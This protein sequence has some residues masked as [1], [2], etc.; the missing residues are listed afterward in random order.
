MRNIF[1]TLSALWVIGLFSCRKDSEKSFSD[2]P[3]IT[4][5]GIS[6]SRINFFDTGVA[7]NITL[8]FT[9]GDG[10]IGR[11]ED[12]VITIQDFRSDTLYKSYQYPFPI[13]GSEFRDHKWLEGTVRITLN[14][15][16]FTPRLDS[17]HLAEKKDTLY[18]K[19]YLKDE[20]GN[21]SNT[22]QTATIYMHG[23]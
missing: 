1:L 15:V 8:E 13:I 11:K 6:N 16:F 9:D 14:T 19:I 17:L 20:A 2:T 3:Q 4:Y 23:D 18:F 21:R 12:S 22:V 7:C 10:N 5:K